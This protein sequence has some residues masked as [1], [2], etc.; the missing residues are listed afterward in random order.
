MIN[1]ATLRRFEEKREKRKKHGTNIIIQ[2]INGQQVS[3]ELITVKPSSL[4]LLNTEGKDVSVDIEEI[5]G[6]TVVKKSKAL[7]GIGIGLVIGGASGAYF[8]TKERDTE[9]LGI[10]NILYIFYLLY[11]PS[12]FRHELGSIALGGSIGAVVGGFIGAAIGK[13]KTIL[14]EGMS[15]SE[16]QKTLDKLRKKARIRDYK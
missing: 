4:L 11:P 13:D 2:K 5:K 12:W 3:G 1:C 6:I 16:T 7:T 9:D 14:L 15:D 10:L 8:G